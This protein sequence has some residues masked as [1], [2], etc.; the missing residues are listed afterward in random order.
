LCKGRGKN[1]ERCEFK[2]LHSSHLVAPGRA[3]GRADRRIFS[4]LWAK[5]R[6]SLVLKE[7]Y[8][9]TRGLTGPGTAIIM[10]SDVGGR[11]ANHGYRHCP[12]KDAFRRPLT[13]GSEPG[14]P[15]AR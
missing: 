2:V 10:E 15:T 8:W 14:E 9:R 13:G 7:L 11:A 5:Y 12:E 4:Q 3:A 1:G 6:K